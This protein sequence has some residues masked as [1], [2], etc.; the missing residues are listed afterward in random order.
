M[1]LL[2]MNNTMEPVFYVTDEVID[3]MINGT[4]IW[5]VFFAHSTTTV[6]SENPE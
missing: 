5:R 3:G 2:D 6:L 1:W 4:K